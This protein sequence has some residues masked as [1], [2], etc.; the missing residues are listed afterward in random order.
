[1]KMPQQLTDAKRLD[2]AARLLRRLRASIP[3][4]LPPVIEWAEANVHLFGSQGEM[5]SADNTP[6]T[7]FPIELCDNPAMHSI[8]L[9]KPIRTGGSAA[10]HVVMCRWIVTGHGGIQYNWPKDEKAEEMWD[11]EI[12]RILRNCPAVRR[13]IPSGGMDRFKAQKGLIIFPNTSLTV[14]GVWT[15][16][17]LD[18]D[19]VPYQINE[20]IH[21]W[22]P[23]HLAKAYGRGEGC[24]FPIRLNISN[25]GV[26]GDQLHQQFLAG[27][28]RQWEVL[29][30][31]C[32]KYHIMRT[33]WAPS[34]P[35]LGG[36]WYDHD[37]ARREDGTYDYNIVKRTLI[38]KMPCGC[39][40]HDDV[41]ERRALSMSGRYSEPFNTGATPGNESMTYQAV[42]CH[43]TNWLALVE[44]RNQALRARKTGDEQT[45]KIYIQQRECLF[46][47]D[48]LIPFQGQ[49][50][51]NS[52]VRKNREGLKDRAVRLWAADKQRGYKHLGQLSHYW[53]VIEDVLQNCSS[54]IVFEGLVQTDSELISVL[55]DHECK[56]SDGV[57]DASW[58]TKTVLEFCYRNGLNAVMGNV[59]GKGYFTHTMYDGSR[60]QK[61]YSPNK[62]VHAE[63]NMPPRFDYIAT[64][65]GYVA[66]SEE[67]V[68]IFYNK[69][70]LLAN[71][72]FIRDHKKFVM[73]NGAAM[74]PPRIPEPW[75]YIERVIPGD[76]SEEFKLQNES[77]ERVPNLRPK[78]NDEVE[79]FR[80]MRKDDHLLMCCAYIDLLKDLLGLLGERLAAMGLPPVNQPKTE[81]E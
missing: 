15:E 53:L 80:K 3:Q 68:V 24:D 63:L 48:E 9:V 26:E 23:G 44:Q 45:W 29:C 64:R 55:D 30:P 33:R 32:K 37:Q 28:Q 6:W 50:V 31:G 70:G 76:V 18:S 79:G 7:R 71:H 2:D 51:V 62:L 38:F 74:K 49:I 21:A 66:N 14:Q 54:Q 1:M 17:A 52:A 22:K 46:Y 77:W 36:L 25:A 16:D 34:R 81:N 8:T 43:K 19:T 40:V 5:Y 72:F 67:P 78:T 60:V 47:S 73:A 41:N 61:Y 11:K 56:H 4:P 20:E 75:E 13:I 59:S 42:A 10:G 12:D 69:A 65:E 39:I 35:E 27:T 58:D 57:I